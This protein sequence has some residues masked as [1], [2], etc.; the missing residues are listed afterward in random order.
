MLFLKWVCVEEIPVHGRSGV[1]VGKGLHEKAV[2]SHPGSLLSFHVS[3]EP[4][5]RAAFP[6][7]WSAC[8]GAQDV[9]FPRPVPPRTITRHTLPL[10][11]KT[12]WHSFLLAYP[13]PI[14]TQLPSSWHWGVYSFAAVNDAV[15]TFVHMCEDE[16]LQEELLD[17][18]TCI[19]NS[20][21]NCQTAILWWFP[22][23]LSHQQCVSM[24]VFLHFC[25][26]RYYLI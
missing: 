4:W 13:I 9:A 25:Q 23:L 14:L 12:A 15:Q 5:K 2:S 22:S 8:T 18:C 10:P 6:C 1:V 21:R 19:C 26:H 20:D 16:F 11:V 24:P 17:V 3:E 7:R